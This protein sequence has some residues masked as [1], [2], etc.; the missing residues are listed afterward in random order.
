MNILSTVSTGRKPVPVFALIH[1]VDG[2]GK[3]TFASHAPNPLFIGVETGSL[4]LDVARLPAPHNYAEFI[5]QLHAMRLEAH[6]YKTLVI[7]SLDWLEPLIWS[8]ICAEANVVSIEKFEGGYGKGYVR[9]LD[10]WREVIRT[11]ALLQRKMHIILIAHTLVK[12]FEDPENAAAYDRYIV[13]LN[14]KAAMLVRQAVDC[15]LFC[16]YKVKVINIREGAGGAK[17]KG[18]GTAE[19]VMY[20]ETR[21]A[22]DAKNRFNLP[23]EM[24]LDWKVLGS[25]IKA[26]YA[27]QP[28]PAPAEPPKPIEA[29]K[30]EPAKPDEV[31]PDET[32]PAAEEKK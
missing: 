14:E 10:F 16:N 13:A 9:A 3:S 24:P 1:G 2:I 11:L 20:T 25:H 31:P 30:P 12:K 27:A 4:Q 19:R 17:G 21:P 8:Q 7:D 29:A 22:W 23:F 32:L 6:D 15:V 26:F 5:Q 28:K 18:R